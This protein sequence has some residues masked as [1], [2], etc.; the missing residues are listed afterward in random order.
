MIS[1]SDKR[2]YLDAC[3]ALITPIIP[4]AVISKIPFLGHK[5]K[6]YPPNAQKA[7]TET[8]QWGVVARR[9]HTVKHR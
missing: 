7:L 8:E 2:F 4:V 5:V 9:C 1:D 6:Q 3:N